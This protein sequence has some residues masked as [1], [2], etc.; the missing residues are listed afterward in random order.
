MKFEWDEAKSRT[1][2]RKH[3]FDSEE[4]EELFC[5]VLLAE[6][7]LRQDYG[8]RRWVGL[9]MLRGR[10]VQVVFAEREPE[11]IRIISIRKATRR[12]QKEY[13]KAVQDRL[14]AY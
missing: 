2:V 9:G 4:A 7:D 10:T 14:G 6:P 3:G 13:E 1:N 11:V 8:E 5:G 12:E